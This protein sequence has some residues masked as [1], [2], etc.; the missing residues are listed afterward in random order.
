MNSAK[1]LEAVRVEGDA[2]LKAARLGL[3]HPVPCC[4]GWTVEEVVRHV[5]AVYRHKLPLLRTLMTGPPPQPAPLPDGA[6]PIEWLS[7]ALD[8]LILALAAVDPD[9]PIWTWHPTERRARFW[10]RRMALETAVHRFDAQSAHAIQEP[11]ESELA[12]DGV[13]EILELM[14][15][16]HSAQT[17]PQPPHG[18]IHF[19]CADADASWGVSIGAEGV[20]WEA[21]PEAAGHWEAVASGGASEILLFLWGRRP[22]Q[23][24][25]VHDPDGLLPAIRGIARDATQ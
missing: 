11:I 2:L 22:F 3:D 19:R 21:D 20:T 5:A 23:V 9:T 17:P 10:Y 18:A 12:A 6:D 24:L 4:P 13:E 25:S 8:E 7:S 14:I 16:P 1:Y 15:G